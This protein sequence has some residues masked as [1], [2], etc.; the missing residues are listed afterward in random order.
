MSKQP[1]SILVVCYG[2]ICRSP[3]AEA[4][5]RRELEGLGLSPAYRV[6]SAGVGAL[7]GLP[8]APLAQ[9]V[10]AA[11]GLLLESH[12]SRRLT[13]EMAQG[14]DLLIALDE[15]VEDAILRIAGDLP[16]ESW[17]VD[18]P[19]GG[20]LEGYQRAF[21]DLEKHV[22]TCVAGLAG[23]DGGRAESHT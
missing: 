6:A 7:E 12:R 4:L 3:M 13:A 21:T 22:V 16:M 1:Q 14:A 19:Y 17:P 11:H 2:N 23:E 18:D 8:A 10:A 15:F 9:E 20:P 5:F